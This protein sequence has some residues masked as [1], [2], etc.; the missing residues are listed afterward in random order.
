[1]TGAL[2]GIYGASGA[3]RS[4]MPS[5]REQPHVLGNE[6]VFVDDFIE[7]DLI[8]GH[9]VMSFAEFCAH[10]V[11]PKHI[12]IA[13][14]DAAIRKSL[15]EKCVSAGLGFFDVRAKESVVLDDVSIGEGALLSPFATLT[16][17]IVIGR[18]FHGNLYSQVEHD[19]VLG[20]YVTFAPGALCNGNV[21]IADGVYVGSG[22]VIRQGKPGEPRIIGK[23]AT[24]GMGAIVLND[25]R[26]GSTVVGNP[27]REL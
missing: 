5:A 23:G 6:I 16:S 17:N 1:M 10:N 13:I 20:D 26:P 4:I 15:A 18:H 19:C 8:N 21:H 22:A 2:Y 24:I 3:G 27:A 9:Q 7:A 12:A 11:G 14:A 25:V